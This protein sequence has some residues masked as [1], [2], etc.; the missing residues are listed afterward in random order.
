MVSNLRLALAN[1]LGV[2]ASEVPDELLRQH[3][4]GHRASHRRAALSRIRRSQRSHR[5][6]ETHHGRPAYRVFTLIP[7]YRG[8]QQAA[9]NNVVAVS[10]VKYGVTGEIHLTP[11]TRDESTV[12]CNRVEMSVLPTNRN[13]AA[14]L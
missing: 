5:T 7:I 11:L 9:G 13:S 8:T 12:S 4:R 3:P 10:S 14:Q 6:Q 1:R 2:Q